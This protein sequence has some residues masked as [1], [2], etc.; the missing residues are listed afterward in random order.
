[1]K[2]KEN[3]AVI[4]L[5]TV[6]TAIAGSLLTSG[7]MAWYDMLVKPELTPPKWIF[8]VAWNIIFICTTI[9]AIIVWNKDKDCKIG[10]SACFRIFGLF[11]LNA[12]LNVLWSALFF[13]M[14][15][16]MTAFAEMIVLEL[17]TILLAAIVWKTSKLAS[18][19]LLPYVIW[20]GFAVYLTY[21]IVLLN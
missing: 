21:Q 6:V 8:P 9:A 1:M 10:R 7:G 4:P 3:Y 17:T 13:R 11:L 15:I 18:V 5:I 16:L 14:H 20:G 12:I 2:F 19:L